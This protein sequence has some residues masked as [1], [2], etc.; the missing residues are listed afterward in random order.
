MRVCD[1]SG[2]L[3]YPF[4]R[5]TLRARA[6]AATSPSGGGNASATSVGAFRPDVHAAYS[7]HQASEQAERDAKAAA[8]QFEVDA[9]GNEIGIGA[10]GTAEERAEAA[11]DKEQ[12]FGG[13]EGSSGSGTSPVMFGLLDR[14]LTQSLAIDDVLALNRSAPPPQLASWTQSHYVLNWVGKQYPVPPIPRLMLPTYKP[15]TPPAVRNPAPKGRD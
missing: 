2:R 7:A 1:R 9:N 14:H 3:Y 5:P 13:G 8:G 15:S 6:A 4:V 12:L 11:R 10:G